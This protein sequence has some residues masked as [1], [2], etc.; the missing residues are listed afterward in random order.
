VKTLATILAVL[1]VVAAAGFVLLGGDAPVLATHGQPVDVGVRDTRSG[2][3][4]RAGVTH[5]RIVDRRESTKTGQVDSVE[6]IGLMMM[7][8]SPRGR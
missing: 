2:R 8:G 3:D 1:I 4:T 6:V 5:P 7:L